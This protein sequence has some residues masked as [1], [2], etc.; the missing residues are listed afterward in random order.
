MAG[1]QNSRMT[2]AG[3]RDRA[4][5][6]PNRRPGRGSL[7]GL[8]L[9]LPALI[10]S[11]AAQDAEPTPHLCVDIGGHTAPVRALVF[12]PDSQH[13]CSA[14]WDK[15]VRVWSVLDHGASGEEVRTRAVLREELWTSATTV[16]W[17]VGRGLRGSI[18]AMDCSARTGLVAI[19][20]YGARGTTG[21]VI[22]ID[23]A[24]GEFREARYEHRQTIAALSYS[25]SGQWL[26]SM[27]I[28]GHAL[29]WPDQAA[30]PRVLAR[31]DEEVYGKAVAEAIAGTLR[32]RPIV[33]VGDRCV[34]APVY[35]RAADNGT[36]LWQIRQYSLLSASPQATLPTPHYGSIQALAGSR[37][38]RY[39]ASAD[40]ANQ[41]FLWDL[42]QPQPEGQL[43]SRTRP[44]IALAFSPDGKTLVAGTALL[45]GTPGTELQVWDVARGRLIRKR[46]LAEPVYAC[47]ISPDG[48]Q[49][50]YVGRPGH[51][52]VVERLQD[53][54]D[55]MVFEG[56]RQITR[57][58]FAPQG[59]DYQV[60]FQAQPDF[61]HT[62]SASTFDPERLE[63]AEQAAAWDAPGPIPGGWSAEADS[64]QNRIALSQAGAARGVIQLDR[65]TQG[66]VACWGWIPDARGQPAALAVGTNVQNGVFVYGL[67]KAGPCPLL[68]YFRGHYDVVR[69]LAASRDGRY[70][71]SGSR[72]G[73]LCY[74]HLAAAR[75][76]S[77]LARRWGAEVA[78]QDGS[79]VVTAI[80]D[81]GPLYQKGVRA[82]DVIAAVFWLAE[83]T[84]QTQRAPD[85]IRRQLAELPW[86]VQVGFATQRAGQPRQPFNLIGAWYP[87]LSLYTTDRDWVAWTS[88][89][90]YACSPGGERLIGWQ[91]NNGLGQPPSFYS[92]ERFHR[93]LYRPDVIQ[94]ILKVGSLTKVLAGGESAATGVAQLRPPAVRIVS[95]GKRRIEQRETHLE[96]RA[97]AESQPGRPVVELRLLLDGR[98][99]ERKPVPSGAG[100]RGPVEETW[101]VRLT[102][103]EHRLTVL[104]DDAQTQGS[105]EIF[106]RCAT[107]AAR[108]PALYGLAIGISSYPGA[109]R[110]A[111]GHSDAQALASVVRSSSSGLFSQVE[112]KT[113]TDAQATR[114]GIEA[115]LKWL[116]EQMRWDDVAVVFFAGHGVND[117]R[118]DFYLFPVDGALDDLPGTC[119]SDRH[120]K[121]FCQNTPGKLLLLIDACHSGGI[122]VD[123]NDLARDLGRNDYGVIVMASSLGSERSQEN[124]AWG[125]GAFT[126]AL[127]DG[128][129]GAADTRQKGFVLTPIDLDPYVY[130]TVLELTKYR[131]TPI[132]NKSSVAPFPLTKSTAGVAPK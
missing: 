33:V 96:I 44:V 38:G 94:K 35:A 128:L 129:R 114:S 82:G 48:T 3:Y 2:A 39:L 107:V 34:M 42:D 118:G 22:W 54:E 19:G 7:A 77:V 87:L 45:E 4:G 132:S 55:E 12:T 80:D 27:D 123:V 8:L 113:L 124:A 61:R 83:G 26:A 71:V 1:Q 25:A 75:K 41:L 111:Y 28:G 64:E 43:L 120:I 81:L 74:W 90:Y 126:R 50:A 125:G 106:V 105:D 31:S 73:T 9:V 131:Q 53:P 16:R 59:P 100:R 68:C 119:L 97:A 130:Y 92:A 115:G 65:A 23:P 91:I 70:L 30:Q 108:K 10:R 58:A 104:A 17:E 85:E 52:V 79:L 110:L 20:G 103:G 98:P 78:V 99:Y 67:A 127:V 36:A 95:P 89:G 24:G 112:I 14:G 49:L 93:A 122:R 86:H 46:E 32:F 51:D 5:G 63:F 102:P 117:A 56:G 60:R 6:H 29:L 62:G 84:V 57:V 11:A 88:S 66:I 13:L 101:T 121:T 21:E 47:A 18:Y 15:A 116:Q 37:D 69:G 72:D 109:L 76:P 40:A